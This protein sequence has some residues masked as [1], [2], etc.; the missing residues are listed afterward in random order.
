VQD[1]DAA[2]A[3]L[4]ASGWTRDGDDWLRD[5]KPLAVDVVAHQAL[6]SAQEVAVNLQSQLQTAGVRVNV[7]FL[8]EAS[9][10][11]RVW[12][13]RNFDVVLSQWTFD[14]NEDVREQFHSAGTRNFTSYRNAQV[15]ALLDKA[16]DAADP[17]AR[18]QALR[19]VHRIVA[20][21]Q[22]MLFLWTLDSYAALSVRV[23]NVVVHPFTFFT[24]APQWQM[25]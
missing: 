22:P 1:L 8:D 14:R 11:A 15:D 17:F 2:E 13:D 18:K 7:E 12:R 25:K 5:G 3:A 4:S 6:E 20:Y 19:E 10:K 24:F 16:R 21:D 23:K 9:W